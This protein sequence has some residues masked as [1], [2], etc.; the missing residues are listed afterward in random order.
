[1]TIGNPPAQGNPYKDGYASI[2]S[3]NTQL[4]KIGGAQGISLPGQSEQALNNTL[5]IHRQSHVNNGFF[6]TG[7]RKSKKYRKSRRNRKSKKYRKKSRR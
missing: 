3:S 1:M 4:A 5:I 7:G 2:K 6:R